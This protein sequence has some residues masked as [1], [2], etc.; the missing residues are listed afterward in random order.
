MTEPKEHLAD[1]L[2]DA[3]AMEVQSATMMKKLVDR[4]EHYPEL[5]G[6]IQRHIQETEQQAARLEGCMKRHGEKTSTVK[7]IA[8]KFTA[9]IQGLSGVVVED[10]VV[11]GHLA[12]YVFEHYEIA[13][14][15]VLIAAAE[16]AGDSETRSVCETNLRE[17]E[18]MAAWL[19]DNLP[20]TTQKFLQ[21]DLAD[22]DAK[23]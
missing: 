3:H 16:L 4:L 6:R 12:H 10:E 19:A 23:R 15:R 14:Y 7:D 17:E 8:G 13:S 9:T 21:R 11:K 1:W 22:L 18:E 5:R 20:A 2:R